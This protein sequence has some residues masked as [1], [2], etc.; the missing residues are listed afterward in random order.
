MGKIINNKNKTLKVITLLLLISDA[1]NYVP[2]GVSSFIG[3]MAR[4][5][6]RFA[7]LGHEH[8][9]LTKL[10]GTKDVMRYVKAE[11][12]LTNLQI[13]LARL[14]PSG[15]WAFGVVATLKK[16]L[17]FFFEKR[18]NVMSTNGTASSSRQLMCRPVH[19]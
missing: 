3:P 1:Y 12:H 9:T 10:T 17:I 13:Y 2:T 7:L 15:N 6:C 19:N 5:H 11:F 18:R 4:E 8:V 16:T 14:S